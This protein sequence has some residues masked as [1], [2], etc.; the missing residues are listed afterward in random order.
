MQALEAPGLAGKYSKKQGRYSTVR[1]LYKESSVL[2]LFTLKYLEEQSGLVALS[3][4]KTARVH[5]LVFCLGTY[6]FTA[7]I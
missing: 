2:N 4:F 7:K 5:V 1:I 6:N 3:H